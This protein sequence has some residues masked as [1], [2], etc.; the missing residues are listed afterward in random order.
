MNH[1][2]DYVEVA[3]IAFALTILVTKAAA[4]LEERFPTLRMSVRA[5]MR[6]GM[7]RLKKRMGSRA[8]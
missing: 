6:T 4:V 2:L 1:P 7:S 5:W 3:L 8:S